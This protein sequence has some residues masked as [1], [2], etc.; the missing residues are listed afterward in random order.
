MQADVSRAGPVSCPPGIEGAAYR[1]LESL[2]AAFGTNAG[3]RIDVDVDFAAEALVLTVQGAAQ[4]PAAIESALAS[5][6]A[7]V[8]LHRGSLTS[9]SPDGM[10]MAS[11]TL[12]LLADA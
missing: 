4:E 5:V 6:R 11:V 12:P 8:D 1:T 3:Q 7:A 9:T 2:L 10:W